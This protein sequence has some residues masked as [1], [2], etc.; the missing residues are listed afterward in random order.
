V[1]VGEVTK[2]APAAGV[3]AY[4]DSDSDSDSDGDDDGDD[5][6]LVDWRAK[7]L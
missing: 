3:V 1:T 2:D 7:K 4:S 6:A 5:D